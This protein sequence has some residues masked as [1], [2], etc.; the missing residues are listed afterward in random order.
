MVRK[1]AQVISLV[2]IHNNMTKD[3]LPTSDFMSALFYYV[4]ASFIS[5]PEC[6]NDCTEHINMLSFQFIFLSNRLS[7]DPFCTNNT[8]N[9]KT[10]SDDSC[11]NVPE[12][13]FMLHYAKNIHCFLQ[14][15]VP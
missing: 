4:P 12:Q 7:L 6:S 8:H 5:T 13:F 3:T 1:K 9:L 15:P 14:L 10:A 2:G 11:L